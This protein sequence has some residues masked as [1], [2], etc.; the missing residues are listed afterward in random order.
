M[1]NGALLLA[2]GVDHDRLQH[3]RLG[4]RL[5]TSHQH[6]TTL[7]EPQ[8]HRSPRSG[9]RIDFGQF[10]NS[11]PFRIRVRNRFNDNYDHYYVKKADAVANAA[12][13]GYEA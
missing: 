2:S 10:G 1:T 12:R 4:R 6:S 11:R 8:P 7:D 9:D 3:R 5:V 13:Q